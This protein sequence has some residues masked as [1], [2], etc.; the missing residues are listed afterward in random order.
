M[1]IRDDCRFAEDIAHDQIGAFATD[2]RKCEKRIKI[3][4]NFRVVYIAQH[5]HA[6]TD[7]FGLAFAESAGTNDRFNFF[8]W[9][10]SKRIYIRKFLI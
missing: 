5:A 7:I 6:A 2:T 1:G 9:G 8:H 10:V 3:I 4:R